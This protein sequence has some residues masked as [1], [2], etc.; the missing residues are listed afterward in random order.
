M[1]RYVRRGSRGIA[2]IDTSG[3]NPKLKYVFDVS[4][5][6]GRENAR[7]PNLWEY[8][9][10]SHEKVV[11]NALAE[12][13]G[14]SGELGL[15]DQLE[16]IA[17][18]RFEEY[19]NDN[20]QDI[21]GILA[22]SFLETYDDYNVGVV[23]KNVATVSATYTMLT[24]CGIDPKDYFTHE[25]FLPVFDFNTS[26][27]LAALGSVISNTSEQ[28][29]RQIEVT[30][31]TYER[32]LTRS[33]RN[34][35][36]TDTHEN[37]PELRHQRG[38]SDPQPEPDPADGENTRQ[39]R[40]DA[41][42]VPEGASPGAVEQPDSLGEA[43]P[44]LA[45]DRPGGESPLG[46]DDA[47]AGAG[48]RRDGG[49]ESQESPE[50]GGADE[51][52]ESAGR[53]SNPERTDL[54]LN[55]FGTPIEGE[56][57]GLFP[58]EAEQIAMIEEAESVSIAPFA[59]SFAQEDIDHTLRLGSNSADTRMVMTDLFQ[60]GKPLEQI[61]ERMKKEYHGGVGFHV[62]RGDFS[63]WYDTEGIRFARGLD[64]RFARN[65]QILSWEDA[66]KRI[67]ELLEEGKFGTN[68][69]LEETESFIRTRLAEALWD[70]C[71]DLSDEAREQGRL[72]SIRDNREH[73]F[74]EDT[75][76]IAELLIQPD[77]R[78]EVITQCRQLL[79]G[80]ENGEH[81]LRFRRHRLY[82]IIR[83]LEDLSL[84]LREYHAEMTDI[85]EIPQFIT[86][87]E[88]DVAL[89]GGSNV[90]GA[91]G[92]IYGFFTAEHTAKEKADFLK[93]EYGIGGSSHSVSFHPNSWR[94]SEGKGLTLKKGDCPPVQMSWAK[95]AQRI[96]RLINRGLFLTP[97]EIYPFAEPVA[98]IC[99]E[100]GKL[101]SKPFNRA[102][103]DE[104]GDIYDV[105]AGTF[106][107]TGLGE[108]NF[109]SLRDGDMQKFK[110][111]FKQ[112]EAFRFAG[113]RLI[114]LP[115]PEV[116]KRKDSVLGKLSEVKSTN[117]SHKPKTS[118]R[119]ER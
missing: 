27:A 51:Q 63:V 45:G 105:V 116:P 35:E 94:N 75:A 89:A 92:R 62:E 18:E 113:G 7:R 11:S 70:L 115:I 61:V 56:Q 118:R 110:E 47:R 101:K 68:V 60:K 39:V 54:Q 71:S 78:N 65:S 99:D 117:T 41:Q 96:T 85:A 1:R 16:R 5:T 93:E 9:E 2:L 32:E 73:G 28:I 12:R 55:P 81:L 95:A 43:V 72:S 82:E 44:P 25:D 3:D 106:L 109:S 23:F 83:G 84:P 90:A 13:F 29:L 119:E 87:D 24:R 22:N 40:Q 17:F 8:R 20:S 80:I 67:G 21:L 10:E 107:I 111:R 50:M 108:E 91:K 103:R 38:L 76:H 114:V 102:L 88:I 53:G 69:E 30:I 19:W 46:A 59:F 97:S 77:F 4:D 34:E 100:E 86:E 74:P 37:Q 42:A 14:V 31:K 36:R 48:S 49:T 98:L 112:P 52:P 79:S 15:T 57:L 26:E 33:A 66:A 6:G 64:A 58:S 104:D